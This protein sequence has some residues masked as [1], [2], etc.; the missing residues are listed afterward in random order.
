MDWFLALS[1]SYSFFSIHFMRGPK[2]RACHPRRFG[3]IKCLLTKPPPALGDAD[4]E[5]LMIPHD[6]GHWGLAFDMVHLDSLR[7][8]LIIVPTL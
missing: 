5:T 1:I 6:K 4:D 7:F 2:T 8:C 3:S